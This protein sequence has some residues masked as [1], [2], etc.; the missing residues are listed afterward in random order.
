MIIILVITSDGEPYKSLESEWLKYCNS[1]SE[2]KVFFI[3]L[4]IIDTDHKISSNTI[5]I[6]GSESYVPGIYEK[7]MKSIQLILSLKEYDTVDFFVRTNISS[8]WIFSRLLLFL[9]DKPTLGYCSSG[10]I[11][12]YDKHVFPSGSNIIFSRD[13]AAMLAKKIGS[14][15]N[16]LPDDVAIGVI[17]QQNNINIQQYEWC[18]TT[19]IINPSEYP[20]FINSISDNIFTIRNNILDPGL[21]KLYEVQKYKMLIDKF[22]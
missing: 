10:C 9:K 16:Q 20:N 18:S 2:V 4:N 19:H 1:N 5:T 21:R 6:N 7:T 15:L 17:L 12:S 13:V 3:R 11:M 8:F 22:Y 14:P